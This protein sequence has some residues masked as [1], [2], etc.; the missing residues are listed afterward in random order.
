MYRERSGF[1]LVE[2][3]TAVL[4]VSTVARIAVPNYQEMKLKARAAEVTVAI[5]QVSNAALQHNTESHAW[6]EDTG[7]GEKPPE[8]EEYLEGISF[9]RQG[10]QLDWENW[11]LPDGLPKHPETRVLLGVSVVT[12]DEDLGNAV[13]EMLGPGRAHFTLESSY[14]FVLEG[15]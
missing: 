2:A 8:L 9:E 6:P 10:Y 4:I 13:V 5:R 15:M 12:E 7:P 14:T 11:R 3:M 1:T